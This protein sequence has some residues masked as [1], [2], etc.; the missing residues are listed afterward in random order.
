MYLRYEQG[1]HYLY[2][3]MHLGTQRRSQTLDI[4]PIPLPC[5]L[6][7]PGNMG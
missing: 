1:R 3:T 2:A 7:I 6:G 4:N 5:D